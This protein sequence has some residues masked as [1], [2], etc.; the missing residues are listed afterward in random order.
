M[1]RKKIYEKMMIIVKV[2]EDI[3]KK[4]ELLINLFDKYELIK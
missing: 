1:S 2:K 3:V 4:N